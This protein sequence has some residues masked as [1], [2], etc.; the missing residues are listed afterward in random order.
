MV[1]LLSICKGNAHIE[2]KLEP[3]IRSESTTSELLFLLDTTNFKVVNAIDL[4]T[5]V[6]ERKLD[7]S[8]TNTTLKTLNHKT[9]F[10]SVTDTH[11]F[12]KPDL[13]KPNMLNLF[14]RSFC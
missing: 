10:I 13:F 14:I 7:P 1:F 3:D 12:Y 5:Q 2:K 8:Q 6:K 11:T 9:K 4:T